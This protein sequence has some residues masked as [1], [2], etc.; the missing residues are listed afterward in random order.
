M[1]ITIL[2]LDSKYGTNTVIARTRDEAAKSVKEFL[3]DMPIGE[4]EIETWEQA[5][6][7]LDET[8][9]DLS[10]LGAVVIVEE[11]EIEAKT[12]LFSYF[13]HGDYRGTINIVAE[14]LACANTA[15]VHFLDEEEMSSANPPMTAD[16]WELSFVVPVGGD[17]RRIDGGLVIPEGESIILDW[18]WTSAEE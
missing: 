6:E 4:V 17:I 1:K 15:L 18:D 12:S 7:K 14:N 8:S 2:I 5:K 13:T 3:T 11:M 16:D 9:E 10:L